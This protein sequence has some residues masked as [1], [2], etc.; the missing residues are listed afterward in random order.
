MKILKIAAQSA[1]LAAHLVPGAIQIVQAQGLVTVYGNSCC[2]MGASVGPGFGGGGSNSGNGANG[3][4]PEGEAHAGSSAPA[5]APKSAEQK[6]Q[7][8]EKCEGDRNDA[9]TEATTIYSAQMGVCSS[10]N[11]T[12]YGYFIDQWKKFTGEVLKIG[13]GSCSQELTKNYNSLLDVID[14]RRDYCV[15]KI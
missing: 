6:Q 14:K 12:S 9:R 7:E 1:I 3:S 15:A 11:S 5:P 10:G 4:V 13:N 8:R 2:G